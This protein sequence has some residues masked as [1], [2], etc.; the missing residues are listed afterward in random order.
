M[1]RLRYNV[2][3]SLDGFIADPDGGYDW[4]VA[5]PTVDFDALFAKF[6]TAL[7]GRRTFETLLARGTGGVLPGLRTVVVSET[8]RA[9]DHPTVTVVSGDVAATVR[10]LKAEPG[11]DV[12]L[13]GGGV[14]FRSLLDAGLVDTIE[15]SVVPVLLGD[16][17][18]VLADGRRPSALA[19]TASEVLPSGI[20]RLTYTPAGRPG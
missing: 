9:A 2:A 11:R 13:F 7:M 4:I 19:L 10:A 5:D 17:I 8:L 16:G 18:P 12:W 3:T 20:V 15:V 1:R 6:D 14:L